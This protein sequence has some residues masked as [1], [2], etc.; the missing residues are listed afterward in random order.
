MRR[1]MAQTPKPVEKFRSIYMMAPRKEE[2]THPVQP[3]WRCSG[4]VDMSPSFARRSQ[5]VSVALGPWVARDTSNAS[6]GVL[7]NVRITVTTSRSF[8]SPSVSIHRGGYASA[9]PRCDILRFVCVVF[10]EKSGEWR[11]SSVQRARLITGAEDTG[12]PTG[13]E[14]Q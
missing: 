13:R 5:S 1:V 11:L 8:D 12:S 14:W 9:E 7:W 2:E 6:V 10:L 3:S 4:L